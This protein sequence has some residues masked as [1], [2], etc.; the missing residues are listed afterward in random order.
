MND[1]TG[2]RFGEAIGV[3]G[4]AFRQKITPITIRAYELGL[5]DLDIAEIERAIADAIHQCKFMPSVAELREMAGV[6]PKESRAVIAWAAVKRAI[7]DV[8]E[9]KSVD[10][11]DPTINA[12]IRVMGGWE[13]LCG[14]QAGEQFDV[15]ARKRFEET[16]RSLSSSRVGDDLG[17]PLAGICDR[18]NSAAGFMDHVQEPVRIET[19][20]PVDRK[21]IERKQQPERLRIASGIGDMP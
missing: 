15:W 17:R 21:R 11:D 4:E 14:I 13:E 10:F 2:R 7:R 1:D 12:T 5:R 3:L 20:L 6:V 19:G 8:G 9:Y 18:D 16:Y